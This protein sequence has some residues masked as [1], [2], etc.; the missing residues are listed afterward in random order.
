MTPA[1]AATG[2][3]LK[4]RG[5]PPKL[6]A[7]QCQRG[8][9]MLAANA[10]RDLV[11]KELG[12]STPTC[13]KSV[14][15]AMV[16]EAKRVRAERIAAGLEVLPEYPAHQRKPKISSGPAPRFDALAKSNLAV[17]LLTGT[18][19]EDVAREN[20][21]CVDTL[22][23]AVPASH[24]DELHR[25][26]AKV[27]AE[28]TAELARNGAAAS[29]ATAPAQ[30]GRRALMDT[31]KIRRANEMLDEGAK[32]RD[33]ATELH[34]SEATLY[35]FVPGRR[36]LPQPE[37]ELTPKTIEPLA[38][39]GTRPRDK[40]DSASP[41]PVLAQSALPEY[42]V[43]TTRAA[44]ASEISDRTLQA[45]EAHAAE[46]RQRKE[47]QQK[48]LGIGLAIP[49]RV[50]RS[51]QAVPVTATIE[52]TLADAKFIAVPLLAA[53][54]SAFMR[55]GI[56]QPEGWTPA[57]LW[58]ALIDHNQ[59]VYT[60][61][62]AAPAGDPLID[63]MFSRY[64]VQR[65]YPDRIAEEGDEFIRTKGAE[66]MPDRLREVFLLLR[67]PNPDAKG[68]FI[69]ELWIDHHHNTQKGVKAQFVL[70][71]AAPHTI[72]PAEVAVMRSNPKQYHKLDNIVRGYTLPDVE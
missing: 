35:R 53:A 52:K 6:D 13:Y 30:P 42:T 1:N 66:K 15:P 22:Y 58:Q 64:A 16:S 5:P 27:D 56:D 32:R 29:T 44:H 71:P 55:K 39:A 67:N 12:V 7:V 50:V 40:S 72:H 37:Y 60:A 14:P 26:L 41:V 19:Y 8:A 57:E 51:S 28:L 25:A 69:G 49:A 11:C 36:N 3:P 9:D 54:S 45:A 43:N 48:D 24:L 31:A 47:A 18:S 34:V 63:T 61:Y 10:S 46:L 21:V 33:I 20:G 38:T 65:F 23:R 70:D 68:H 59:K 4:K 62:R 2:R 17:R